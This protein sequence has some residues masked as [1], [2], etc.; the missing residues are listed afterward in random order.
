MKNWKFIQVGNETV[1]PNWDKK[2]Q[3]EDEL[4]GWMTMVNKLEGEEKRNAEKQI[5][6]IR[7]ELN[8]VKI[9]I[10]HGE[11]KKTANAFDFET[12]SVVDRK[13]A[14]K[15]A[16]DALRQA[17]SDRN[18]H[19]GE[20][21]WEELYT[22]AK[23][24]V[25]RA[26]E[27]LE[28]AQRQKAGNESID[29]Q[30]WSMFKGLTKKAE[31]E[32]GNTWEWNVKD[33]DVIDYVT[34][35]PSATTLQRLAQKHLGTYD[36]RSVQ[37]FLVDRNSDKWAVVK[38][39]VKPTVK[40][41]NK[42]G[43]ARSK[44]QLLADVR[45]LTK[46]IKDNPDRPCD[47]EKRLLGEAKEELD[48]RYGVIV[49]NF[50]TGKSKL[51]VGDKVSLYGV[52]GTVKGITGENSDNIYGEPVIEFESEDG[53]K[54]QVPEHYLV[55]TGNETIGQW[56]KAKPRTI[57]GLRRARN[58]M[59]KNAMSVSDLERRIKENEKYIKSLQGKTVD[60]E[61]WPAK[62]AIQEAQDE[63]DM[64]K[65]RIAELTKQGNKKV[66]N[67]SV[68]EYK[69]SEGRIAQIDFNSDGTDADLAIYEDER[70]T[71]TVESKNFSTIRD[72]EQYVQ[73]HGFKRVG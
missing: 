26:K 49:G 35:V 58:A 50:K 2:R 66:K 11:N 59:V 28:R 24:D 3:L 39:G 16:E 38:A 21:Y 65:S 20:L 22:T 43:N 15:R 67:S 23:R 29:K 70:M 52:K 44:E 57:N 42:V 27:N 62:D 33:S 14:L 18:R 10:A 41:T 60:G 32:V 30:E 12:K 55:K 34:G 7:K 19:R 63:I 72:A 6:D 53:K 8:D 1:G 40:S 69:D 64:M 5:A 17:E 9:R 25:E 31:E 54:K 45:E 37:A 51:S 46:Y 13:E 56:A 68:R 48:K 61:G 4:R 36:T 47:K 73:S 71:R